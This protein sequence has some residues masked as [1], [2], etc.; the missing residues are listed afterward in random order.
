MLLAQRKPSVVVIT[1]LVARGA[2][3]GRGTVF[4]LERFGFPVWFVPTITLPWHPGHGPATRIVPPTNEFAAMLDD[5]AN[6]PWLDDVGAVISGYL[7]DAEQAEAVA[8]FVAIARERNPEL[9]YL[10]DPIAGDKGALYVPEPTAVAI[11]EKLLPIANIATPNIFELSWFADREINTVDEAVH[12]A[13]ELPPERVIVSSTPAF[14][15]SSIGNL[16]VSPN[17]AL[18]AEHTAI[19]GGP[20]GPG[21]LLAALFL[22]RLLDGR[23]EEAALARAAAATFELVARTV[24]RGENELAIAAEQIALEKPMAMVTMRRIAE[25][26]QDG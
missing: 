13:R 6:A 25:K 18:L 10:C 26:P 24:K 11:R 23:D 22:A 21:D 3:G 15:R 12:A 2:V 7:G 19:A 4:A 5:L 1:S 16:L 9:I 14:L 17:G 20:H 8:C